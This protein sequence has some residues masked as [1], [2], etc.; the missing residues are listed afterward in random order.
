MRCDKIVMLSTTTIMKID[1]GLH[2]E[3]SRQTI[4][5]QATKTNSARSI[6]IMKWIELIYSLDS[7]LPNPKY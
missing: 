7:L 6:L 1:Q 4:C 2:T 5:N 3:I